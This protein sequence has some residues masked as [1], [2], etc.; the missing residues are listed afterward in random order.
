MIR[1]CFI[2][3]CRN[4]ATLVLHTHPDMTTLCDEHKHIHTEYRED[5]EPPDEPCLGDGCDLCDEP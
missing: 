2:D 1:Y 3:G 4:V 5:W